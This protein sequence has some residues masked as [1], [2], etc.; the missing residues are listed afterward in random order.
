[1]TLNDSSS[2]FLII[3]AVAILA[4]VVHGLWFSGRSINRRLNSQSK[5]DQEIGKS[6]AV[7]KVRIICPEDEMMRSNEVSSEKT[8][9]QLL[10]TEGSHGKK[11]E[12]D[13]L[14]NT[15]NSFSEISD[16]YE[17]NLFAAEGRPYKG[18]DLEE[19]L[20]KFGMVRDDKD[21]YCACQL[22]S[23]NSRIIYFRLCSLE[24]PYSFPKEMKDFTTRSLALYMHLPQKGLCF[25]YF[26]A[27]CY[28][29]DSIIEHFGGV[30]KDNNNKELSEDDISRIALSLKNYD[31]RKDS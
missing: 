30:K 28:A 20:M 25:P 2:L 17:I 22:L 7:G 15:D 1:M 23:D 14:E 8:N 16:T 9:S 4:L 6:D 18:L 12:K 26:K 11:S 31:K 24:A 3:G 13:S 19:L 21:I 27:M 29:A 10:K 5:E